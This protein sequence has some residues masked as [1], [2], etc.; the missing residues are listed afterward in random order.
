MCGWR[1]W[2]CG[3]SG[4]DVCEIELASFDVVKTALEALACVSVGMR[5]CGWLCVLAIGHRLDDA[6]LFGASVD[7]EVF[8]WL[9]RGRG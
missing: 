7:G 2:R 6:W 8:G 9:L 4:A 5:A 1:D 3:E